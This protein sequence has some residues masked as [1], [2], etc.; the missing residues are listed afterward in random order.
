MCSVTMFIY[1]LAL[2]LDVKVYC[3]FGFIFIKVIILGQL[4]GS[5]ILLKISDFHLYLP[6]NPSLVK[7]GSDYQ[8]VI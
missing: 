1:N 8:K 4:Y 5:Q 6:T 3:N 7:T 2:V